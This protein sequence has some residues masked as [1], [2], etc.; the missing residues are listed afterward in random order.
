VE[1]DDSARRRLAGDKVI[2]IIYSIIL[3]QLFIQRQLSIVG[4]VVATKK[5][6]GNWT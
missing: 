6:I 1:G 5:R 2:F 4:M 3:V